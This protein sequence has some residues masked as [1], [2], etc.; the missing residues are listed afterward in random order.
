MAATYLVFNQF[1]QYLA[2]LNTQGADDVAYVMTTSN[3]AGLLIGS[4]TTAVA[5][6]TVYAAH[7]TN[8]I[9]AGTAQYITANVITTNTEVYIDSLGCYMT[10]M[11]WTYGSPT[12]LYQAPPQITT[13]PNVASGGL[14]YTV[15]SCVTQPA[16]QTAYTTTVDSSASSSSSGLTSAQSN[17]LQS[18]LGITAASL[19]LIVAVLAYLVSGMGGK[20]TPMAAREQEMTKA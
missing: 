16:P 15:V 6:G 7:S 9:I 17:Q 1:S 3:P 4:T 5:N 10:V 11:F 20:S 8:K 2:T 14:A 19:L 18:T 12:T 13:T